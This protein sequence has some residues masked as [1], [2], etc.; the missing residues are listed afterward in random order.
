MHL[1]RTKSSSQ[2]AQ[3]STDNLIIGSINALTFSNNPGTYILT[4]SSDRTIHLSRALPPSKP[5]S[6]NGAPAPTTTTPIASYTTHAHPILSLALRSD[7]AVFASTGDPRAVFLWDVGTNTT[8]PIRRF[9]VENA[10][11]QARGETCCFAGAEESILISGH[12]DRFVRLWD[13]K[14]SSSTK[15]ILV[16]EEARDTVSSVCVGR[17]DVG[18]GHWIV[19]GSYDGRVRWYDV[20]MG[21][22]FV[23]VVSSAPVTSLEVTGDG[24]GVLVGGLESTVRLMDREAGTCLKAYREEGRFVNTE[25][26]VRSCFGAN[27]RWCLSGCD[28][29]GGGVWAWDVLSG[30]VVARIGVEGRKIGAGIG[31]EK[32][33][34]K[35][36]VVSCV[37]WN[38]AQGVWAAGGSD[39][40]LMLHFR[41][42][43]R[44]PC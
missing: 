23:D 17:E 1:L 3:Q 11:G 24:S 33:K 15:P 29:E 20:R 9:S 26:R 43:M 27:E 5:S 21:K 42:W 41:S 8:S 4:G 10:G 22:V 38:E 37:A 34:K 35:R 18:C 36:K 40:E 12:A 39:G 44:K 19:T 25:L 31:E 32:D 6:I 16:L 30:E 14:A 7:N 2:S 28:G 13:L